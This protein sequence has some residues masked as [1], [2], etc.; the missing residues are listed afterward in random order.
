[1]DDAVDAFLRA[2]ATDAVN[3]EVFNVGGDEP[4]SHADLVRLLLELSGRGT[5]RFVEWPPEKRVIDIGSFYADSS[6]F[7]TRTGWAPAVRLRDGLAATLEYYRARY[8]FY[9]EEAAG[10]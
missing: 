4:T 5:C 3:G 10:A 1:V 2:G 7:R 6:R 8:H 9:T